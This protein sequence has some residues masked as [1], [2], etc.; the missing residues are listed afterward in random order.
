MENY[1]YRNE[2]EQKETGDGM[3][4]SQEGEQGEQENQEQE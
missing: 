2:D 4:E 3:E 1:M